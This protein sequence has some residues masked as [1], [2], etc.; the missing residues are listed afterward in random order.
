MRDPRVDK[1]AQL[2]VNYSLQLQKGEYV[3][4]SGSVVTSPLMV[5]MYREALKAGAHPEVIPLLEELPEILYK[6]GSDEQIEFVSPLNYLRSEKYDA[7]IYLWGENNTK[8]LAGVDPGR[9]ALRRR[10]TRVLAEIE[11]R[12]EEQGEFRWCGT[13]F[14]T[15]A[16]AQEAG[17]SLA[18]YEDFVYSAGMLGADDPVAEWRQLSER[19]QRIVEYLSTKKELHIVAKDTDLTVGISGR[20]WINCDG[21]VNFPDGEVFTAPEETKVNGKIRFSYPGIYSG[22]EI[23]DIQL[24]FVNG[25]VVSAKAAK[26]LDLLMALL[27]TDDGARRLGEIAIGTNYRINRFTKN[28]LFDE[29]MGGTI[30][31]ALG[32]CI[33]GTGGKN[34]S[35]IHW[36]MLCDMKDGGEIA[37]DGEVFYRNGKFL[38]FVF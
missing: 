36:D 18:E 2:I 32:S 35:G 9:I 21:K 29:K 27:G 13:L 28:M 8:S 33:P 31:A 7:F 12:R 15:P 37:A 25:E 34:I 14:P 24:E 19:Q 4:I 20:T 10:A 30:H 5:A 6:E 26:G 22:Q 1:L 3:L 17:M 38:D 23:E 11:H 16:N